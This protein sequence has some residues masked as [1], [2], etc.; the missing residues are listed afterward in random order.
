MNRYK[1][2]QTSLLEQHL[3]TIKIPPR[4]SIG[5]IKTIRMS[6]GMTLEQLSVRIGIS[7]QS[8]SKLEKNEV[9]ESITLHSLKKAAES[10]NCQLV[11]AIV[12]IDRSIKKMIHKQAITKASELVNDVDRTM[13][14]EAQRVG[15]T[16]QKIQEI[17]A[18]LEANPNSKLWE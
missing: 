1:K 13:M 9:D 4:P 7:K 11:Y 2:L 10:L 12:P 8:V 3:H 5:W 18:E 6:L 17:A 15:N 16:K 14:L